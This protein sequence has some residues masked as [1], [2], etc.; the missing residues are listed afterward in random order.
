MNGWTLSLEQLTEWVYGVTK[1]ELNTKSP[2]ND[3][4]AIVDTNIELF[5]IEQQNNSFEQLNTNATP[6]NNDMSPKNDVISTEP[7]MYI[8]Y[9]YNLFFLYV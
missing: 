7:G 4:I 3:E 1:D 2:K 5:S 8:L 9:I 6:K